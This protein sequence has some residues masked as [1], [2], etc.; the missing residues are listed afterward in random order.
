M[1]LLAEDINN[2]VGTITNPLPT[3]YRSIKGSPGKAGGL[4]LFLSNIIR[5]VFVVAGI[6]AFI[7]FIIAGFQ[8]MNAAGD[9]KALNAAWSRIWN[10]LLGLV[11]IVASFAL[12]ALISQLFFGDPTY[13]LNPTITGPK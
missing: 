5:L 7:N 3:V 11:V 13:I 12:T 10:S 1:R 6:V 8:Y 2:V 9:T 4:M